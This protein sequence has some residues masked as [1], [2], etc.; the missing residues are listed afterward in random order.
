MPTRRCSA[1]S[2]SLVSLTSM[3]PTLIEPLSIGTSALTQRKSVDLPDPEG[4]IRQMISDLATDNEM[5]RS[6]GVAPNDLC[7]SRNCSSGSSAGEFVGIVS[8]RDDPAFFE[9][10]GGAR[11]RINV[12]E[13]HEHYD[14]IGGQ[15]QRR[16]ILGHDQ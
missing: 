9:A 8:A 15:Q 6:T 2:S 12:R 3:P 1:T 16:L 10:P 11:Q 7:T 4:P 14:E 13:K 5:P